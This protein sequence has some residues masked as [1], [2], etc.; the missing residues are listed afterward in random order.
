MTISIFHGVWPCVDC[1][2][3]NKDYDNDEIKLSLS[4]RTMIWKGMSVKLRFY[5]VQ[6]SESYLILLFFL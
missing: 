2:K 3:V 4:L 5:E 6:V 1:M